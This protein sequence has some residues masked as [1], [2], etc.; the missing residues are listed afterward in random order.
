MAKKKQQFPNRKRNMMVGAVIAVV[1]VL[2]IV[3][4]SFG[5]YAWDR[6]RTAFI[7][8]VN[9]ERVS[10]GTY[11]LNLLNHQMM[12]E[13]EYEEWMNM[14]GMNAWDI[15]QFN[16]DDTMSMIDFAKQ[17][18][19]DNTMMTRVLAMKA[20]EY[21]VN[22]LDEEQ[23][24]Y[25]ETMIEYMHW[26]YG[27]FMME[28]VGLNDEELFDAFAEIFFAENLFF[29]IT[30]D[31]YEFD[32]TQEAIMEEE[33][34]E[35]FA[36]H[37]NQMTRFG[38]YFIINDDYGLMMELV[39]RL[40]EGEEFYDLM[41]LYSDAYLDMSGDDDEDADNDEA[42]VEENVEEGAEE[43]IEEDTADA[44]DDD[45]ITEG[46]EGIE[47]DFDLDDFV[48][49]FVIDFGDIEVDWN[50]IQWM[51]HEMP[52]DIADIVFP[53]AGGEISDIVPL[54]DDWGNI[55]TYVLVYLRDR[56]EPDYEIEIIYFKYEIFI[57]T[58]INSLYQPIMEGWIDAS[59]IQRND[60]AFDGVRLFGFQ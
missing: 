6:S 28:Y 2:V 48:D 12:L 4:G 27:P 36:E 20:A 13:E 41:K 34:A 22:V 14:Q 23:I 51:G 42:D 54:F 5:I 26:V 18:A 11:K 33:F 16:F 52:W 3:G 55:E 35:F 30:E 58:Q 40:E 37:H 43:D 60:R 19:F 10:A 46:G 53:M 25:I 56:I 50:L 47:H 59:N 57:P 29:H 21:G 49:E 38:F 9:G 17:E 8:T 31:L 45:D 15:W 32:D 24:D 7:G 1:V 39:R 44:T